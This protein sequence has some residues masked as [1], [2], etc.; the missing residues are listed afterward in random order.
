MTVSSFQFLKLELQ[1]GVGL[2]NVIV[3]VS[4]SFFLSQ[5]TVRHL[6][7]SDAYTKIYTR[8]LLNNTQ[9]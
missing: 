5:T 8:H 4:L 7:L 9:N 6:A 3:G 2:A 1:A